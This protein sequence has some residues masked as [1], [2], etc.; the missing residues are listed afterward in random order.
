MQHKF[1]IGQWLMAGG[2]LL[3]LGV[4]AAS[5]AQVVALTAAE[6]EWMAFMRE[7]EKV[8]RDVYLVLGDLWG[9]KVFANIAVSEQR[10]MDSIK[11][12]LAKYGLPDPAAGKAV[13]EF[14]NPDLQAMYNQLVEQ[15]SLSLV[16]AL[17]VGVLIEET[18]IYF[19]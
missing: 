2:L 18:D 7:E 14:T 10:H 5:A 4:S 17:E 12:L 6:K 3:W 13:G 15:S 11:A 1:K 8:A 19:L 16:D 9:A